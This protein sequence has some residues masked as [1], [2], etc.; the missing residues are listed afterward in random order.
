MLAMPRFCMQR[1]VASGGSEERASKPASPE[2]ITSG[3]CGSWM[4]GRGREKTHLWVQGIFVSHGGF[5]PLGAL[6]QAGMSVIPVP[7]SSTSLGCRS[8]MVLP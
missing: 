1:H 4:W 7:V 2:K 8:W 5:S 3:G 6:G